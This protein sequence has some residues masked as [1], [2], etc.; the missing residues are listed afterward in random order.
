MTIKKIEEFLYSEKGREIEE[1]AIRGIAENKNIIF[2]FVE[3]GV[4]PNTN[5]KIVSYPKTEFSEEEIKKIK[6]LQKK[7]DLDEYSAF[8]INLRGTILHE[9]GHILYSQDMLKYLRQESEKRNP[10]IKLIQNITNI[11][12]DAFIERTLS[13]EF[14]GAEKFLSYSN[15][16]CLPAPEEIQEM[17][18]KLSEFAKFDRYIT[19]KV[20]VGEELPLTMS[21]KTLECIEE[22]LPLFEKAAREINSLTRFSYVFKIIEIIKK[23]FNDFSSLNYKTIAI[24]KNAEGLKRNPK[25]DSDPSTEIEVESSGTDKEGSN[26]EKEGKNNGEKTGSTENSSLDNKDS[27]GSKGNSSKNGEN[28]NSTENIS[29]NGNSSNDK[30]FDFTTENNQGKKNKDAIGKELEAENQEDQNKKNGSDKIKGSMTDKSRATNVF[31]KNPEASEKIAYE[32]AM[33]KYSGIIKK[34]SREFKKL[35]ERKEEGY[36]RKLSMGS[37]LD[38]RNFCDKKDRIWKSRRDSKETAELY[39]TLVVDCSGSMYDRISTAREAIALM[40]S[41][42]NEAKIPVQVIGFN[43]SNKVE[44]YHV[45]SF[46]D[47]F[48]KKKENIFKLFSDGCNR[49]S[50]TAEY[51]YRQLSA[52]EQTNSRRKDLVI[53]ISDGLPSAYSGGENGEAMTKKAVSILEKSI[54]REVLAIALGDINLQKSLEKEFKKVLLC[55]NIDRLPGILCNILRKNFLKNYQ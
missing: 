3:P 32:D 50:Y 4:A 28:S 35:I 46:N 53:W 16:S 7:Y 41:I 40:S 22:T 51:V 15:E 26:S 20:I 6:A 30:K 21:E 2:Q 49:D 48:E 8:W 43:F 36:E 37:C 39:I 52:L 55:D 1:K 24:I 29:G 25:R 13:E 47:K 5:G 54:Q 33:K 19:F 38:S 12:E 42:A 34:Y 23:Y 27:S 45:L 31:Y 17:D 11:Y 18:K 14:L 44:Q 9:T 10:D